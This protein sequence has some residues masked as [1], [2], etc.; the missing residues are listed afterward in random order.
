MGLRHYH[1]SAHGLNAK[2]A[3]SLIESKAAKVAKIAHSMGLIRIAGN[4]F[5]CPS[6]KDLWKVDNDKLIRVSADMV[7][8]NEKLEAADA[9]N[10]D[11]YLDK[12]MNDL[13]F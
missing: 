1:Y 2:E 13:D 7:D 10:P 11:K 9:D 12:I 6:T 5:E 3:E 4:V 8:N